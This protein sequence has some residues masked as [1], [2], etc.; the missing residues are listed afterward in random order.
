MRNWFVPGIR[1][2]AWLP[3]VCL[4][5]GLSWFWVSAGQEL[6]PTPYYSAQ[7]AAAVAMDRALDYISLVRITQGPALAPEDINA[8]GLIGVQ[9]SPLTTTLASIQIKRTTTNPNFAAL[10]VRLLKEGGVREGD[11]VAV[12]LSGSFPA[13]NVA[14]ITALDTL[15]VRGVIISS[16]G[17]SSWGANRPDLTWLDLE[18]LLYAEGLI[19][20]RSIAFSAGGSEDDPSSFLP[21]GAAIVAELQQRF[22]GYFIAT[23]SLA[24][25]IR[26]RLDL[27][28]YAAR[29]EGYS[30]YINVG[31]SLASVGTCRHARQLGPGLNRLGY[32]RPC[33]YCGPALQVSE[34]G[35]VIN[36]L[37]INHLALRYGLPLDPRPLPAPGTGEVFYHKTRP[38]SRLVPALGLALLVL[39]PPLYFRVKD[40]HHATIAYNPDDTS[41]K[42]K[43]KGLRSI[44]PWVGRILTKIRK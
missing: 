15:G 9:Y 14:V 12:G 16:L 6:L 35:I 28:A 3:L 30:A 31:W 21:A 44:I 22:P 34:T 39:V 5:T 2:L 23:G 42:G 8:T 41:W 29:G 25:N 7:R 26:Q 32:F 24:G 18:E 4:V 10:V 19:R 38:L 17:A 13:L 43:T 20:Q 11:L 1:N 36:L 40:K 27:F 37:D 33:D